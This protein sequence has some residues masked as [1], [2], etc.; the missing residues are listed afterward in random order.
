MGICYGNRSG[1]SLA[2]GFPFHEACWGILTDSWS[3]SDREIQFLFDICRS[4]PIEPPELWGRNQATLDWGHAYGGVYWY[5]GASEEL[6]L[7]VLSDHIN[8][9]G[10]SLPGLTSY[11]PLRLDPKLTLAIQATLRESNAIVTTPNHR[12]T[13]LRQKIQRQNLKT[14]S[15]DVFHQL[16]V[17]I[18]QMILE[19][20]TLP[21]TYAL[22]QASR[23]F[24]SLGFHDQFWKSRFFP[25]RDFGHILE[26]RP[27][28]LS[29]PGKWGAL[30]RVAKPFVDYQAWA[31]SRARIM[32]LASSLRNLVRAAGDSHCAGGLPDSVFGPETRWITAGGTRETNTSLYERSLQLP[33]QVTAVVV[34]TVEIHGRR[35]VSGIR[36]P[37]KGGSSGSFTLGYQH[38]DNRVLLLD[39]KR[40]PLGVSGFCLAIDNFG[41]RGL[42]MITDT[43]LL[44]DWAGE[45]ESLPK[46]KL[47]CSSSCLE[48]I[49][50]LKGTFDVSDWKLRRLRPD[51]NH[52]LGVGPQA[53]FVECVCRGS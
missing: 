13:S 35:Y 25:G 43:G 16:P 20:L 1:A 36:I 31:D 27:Y 29:A 28:F 32:G 45:H 38:S 4:T 9:E 52:A 44:S 34:F 7:G 10:C 49:T 40:K 8:A 15:R 33:A 17:E 37:S 2:Y 23:S 46:R 47:V 19:N 21:D 50:D 24:S 39:C 26:A 12:R 3:P 5:P 51:S 18:R 11:N 6:T 48:R 14:R 53:D 41:I 22:R 30:C 42:S